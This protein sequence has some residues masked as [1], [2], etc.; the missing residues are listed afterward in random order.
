MGRSLWVFNYLY[1]LLLHHTIK[2]QIF[3]KNILLKTINFQMLYSFLFKNI[4]NLLQNFLYL[5]SFLKVIIHK[6]YDKVF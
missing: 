3:Y 6:F 1:L 2:G 4:L 5:K